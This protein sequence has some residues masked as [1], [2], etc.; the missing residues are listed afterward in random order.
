MQRNGHILIVETDDLIRELLERWLGEAGYGVVRRGRPAPRR[1]R[2]RP[3]GHRQHLQPARRRGRIRSLQAAY[4]APILVISARFRRGLGASTNAARELGVRKV[5]PKPFTRE[6]LLA[7]VREWLEELNRGLPGSMLLQD[8]LSR[9]RTMIRL[10]RFS[11]SRLAIGYIAL[12]VLALALFAIPLWSAWRV[13]LSTFKAYVHGE[14]VQGWST[15]ST[16]KAQRDLLPRWSRRRPK[17]PARRNHDPC[18]RVETAACRQS[19]RVA[20]RRSPTRPERTDWCIDIAA[21][22][23]CESLRR[24]R[25]CR[26]DTTSWWAA[27][28]SLFQSFIE[29]FWYG[30]AGATAIV[31]GAGCRPSGG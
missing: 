10:L 2:K 21:K 31:S 25:G 1:G 14:G 7:A 6:E 4:P 15:F 29:R 30:I 22:R 26:A 20:G 17:L 12:S 28:A 9:R 11:P 18:R 27:R 23:R 16:A 3:A 5:L 19:A 8:S 24:M 13:N